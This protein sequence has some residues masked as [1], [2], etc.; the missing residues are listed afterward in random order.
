[1]K[2]AYVG[3]RK[4]VMAFINMKIILLDLFVTDCGHHFFMAYVF[5]VYGCFLCMTVFCV[6]LIWRFDVKTG[7]TSLKELELQFK[8]LSWEHLFF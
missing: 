5:F 7:T 3:G 4:Q 6:R 2:R 1:M 8:F